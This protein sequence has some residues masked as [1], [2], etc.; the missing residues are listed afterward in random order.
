M[1]IR[2]AVECMAAA[3]PGH[4]AFG[5]SGSMSLVALER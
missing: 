4:G 1:E 5:G 2:S 3:P